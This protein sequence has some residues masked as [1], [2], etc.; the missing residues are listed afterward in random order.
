MPSWSEGEHDLLFT[1]SQGGKI[2]VLAVEVLKTGNGIGREI[3]Q[4]SLCDGKFSVVFHVAE[5]NELE[6]RRIG[7]VRERVC[8]RVSGER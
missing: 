8:V 7:Y 6:N 5:K 2:A 1:F 3:E 4:T